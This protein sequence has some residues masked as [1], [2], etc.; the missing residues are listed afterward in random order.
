MQDSAA[1]VA[2]PQRFDQSHKQP[3]ILARG[4]D[5]NQRARACVEGSGH[6]ALLI[7]AW[8]EEQGLVPA[9]DIR[10]PDAGIEVEVG[11]IDIEDL[12]RR[13]RGLAL[14]GQV[15]ARPGAARGR[16]CAAR[17][18]AYRAGSPEHATACGGGWD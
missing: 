14:P 6:I 5:G 9:P 17:G 10:I 8:G 11:L 12:R 7:L 16:E 1:A 13:T 4:Q 18:G 15:P 3:R 2:Q